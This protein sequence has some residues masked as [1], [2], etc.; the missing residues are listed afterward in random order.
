YHALQVTANRRF[1]KGLQFGAAW[2]WSKAM[3][4]NDSDSQAISS[5]VPIR[6]W[7]YGLASFDRTHNVKINWLWDVPNVH[8]SNGV[9]NLV[10]NGWQ[11]SGI[12]TFLSGAPLGV[13]FT[14]T[15]STDITGSPTDLP[16]VVVTGNPVLPKS[17]R[18]FA[19]NFR[20]DVFH[21]PTKG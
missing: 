8:T 18:T 17:E 14:T 20:T 6:V 1:Q 21:L 7:N 4:Y 12:T 19:R 15:V 3:D 16:R 2:T 5:L 9:M 11:L 10:L 13:N